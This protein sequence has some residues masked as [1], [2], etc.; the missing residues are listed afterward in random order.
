MHCTMYVYGCI[1]LRPHTN[2]N[3]QLGPRM[4]K[5]DAPWMRQARVYIDNRGVHISEGWGS[6]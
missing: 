6:L 4:Y 5:A 1:Q 2:K 3:M